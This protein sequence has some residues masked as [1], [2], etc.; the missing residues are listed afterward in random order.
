MHLLWKSLCYKCEAPIN[1]RVSVRTDLEKS[2][3][4]A[5]VRIRPIEIQHNQLCYTFIDKKLKRVCD[6]C[7]ANPVQ[8]NPKLLRNREIG[9]I[10]NLAPR[11]VART[12]TELTQ[13]FD[14]LLRRAYKN[15]IPT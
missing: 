11:S 13:W 12:E 14:G 5:Y 2:F 8:I 3:V 7:F 15:N 4:H 6:A 1:P 9:R 10:K